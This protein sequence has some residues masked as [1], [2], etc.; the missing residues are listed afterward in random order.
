MEDFKEGSTN[1]RRSRSGEIASADSGKNI[2]KVVI[3]NAVCATTTLVKVDSERKDGILLEVVQVLTELDLSIQKAYISSDGRW[4]MGVFHVTDRRGCKIA[5]EAVILHIEKSLG[6]ADETVGSSRGV[7]DATVLELSGTDRPGL[8]SDVFAVLAD[9]HCLVV[10]TK[11]W[12]HNGRVAALVSVEEEGSGDRIED[13]NKVR[14]IETR[15]RNVVRGATASVSFSSSSFR[16]TDTD[17]HLHRM[18]SAIRDYE[19]LAVVSTAS[20]SSVSIQNWEERAYSIVNVHCSDRPKL[21]FDTVCALTDMNYVI[22]HGTINTIGE[23]AYQEFFI[24]HADGGTIS[25]EAEKQRV[26]HCLQS[27]IERRAPAGLRLELIS[28]DPHRRLLL[29]ATRTFRENGLSVT[30]AEVSG[31]DDTE[32]N[33]FYVTDASGSPADPKTIGAI[34]DRIGAG[35]LRVSEDRVERTGPMQSGSLGVESS[36]AGAGLFYL[37]GLVKRNLYNL[38]LIRSCS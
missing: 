14:L 31:K 3:D 7:D 24:R 26:I 5:D 10:K 9:L 21:L 18:M 1:Q 16:G 12:T 27:A 20:D 17:R 30:M 8:L 19:R 6:A 35:N 23:R 11:V 33:V 15:L 25:S 2:D 13:L 28:A 38:G 36:A 29:E 32:A 22:F 37:G 34:I 4:F